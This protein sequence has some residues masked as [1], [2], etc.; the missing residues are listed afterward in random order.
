MSRRWRS[1]DQ[2]G[3]EIR[4]HRDF[5]DPMR[6][7]AAPGLSVTKIEQAVVTGS[8]EPSRRSTPPATWC[9]RLSVVTRQCSLDIGT[10]QPGVSNGHNHESLNAPVIAWKSP[11]PP[12]TQIK[13]TIALITLCC[14][15]LRCL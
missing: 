13:K 11:R 9:T 6:S 4:C 2:P 10:C 15:I 12:K 3:D 5:D 7:G 1:L 8:S 14:Q